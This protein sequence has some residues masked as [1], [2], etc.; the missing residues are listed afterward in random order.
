MANAITTL[1][2]VAV[3]LVAVAL[4][5][6]SSFKSMDT[7]ST[8]WKEM[9]VRTGQIARTN[10]QV[11]STSYTAP[12]VDITVKNTGLVALK[13]FSAWDVVVL[14]YEAD[15]TYHPRW[16]PYTATNPP[17]D[18]QWT[19][20]GIYVDAAT[21]TAEVFQP[22]IL[23][24]EEEMVIRLRLSPAAASNG[25]NLAIIATPNGVSVSTMF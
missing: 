24:P 11:L 17:G 13:D 4:I 1:L 18:N 3:V 15:G 10:I 8:A 12:Q 20:V 9:E 21:S 23:D 14:Y 6:Q 19:V 2:T 7:L 22:N 25:Q 16:L 5:G